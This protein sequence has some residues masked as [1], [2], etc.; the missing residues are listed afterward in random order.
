MADPVLGPVEE[1]DTFKCIMFQ[2]LYGQQIMNVLHY[3]C[4]DP[5]VT[6]PQRYQVCRELSGAL[7]APVTGIWTQLRA[8]Q[9]EELV[10]Q[11]HRVQFLKEILSTYPFFE[12][13][14][15]AE[16]GLVGEAKM[17]N[18]AL[19][20]EKRAE[21][22]ATHPRQ[23]VGRLQLAGVPNNKIHDG[24]F[25]ADY[26]ADFGNVVEDMA[27]TIT[28][29]SGVIVAPVL[30]YKGATLWLDNRIFACSVHPEVRTMNR[31]TVGRGK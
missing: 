18:N 30:S 22:P 13:L 6:P 2:T 21:F 16:G 25:D 8:N 7:T 10:H 12:E 31:R 28:L 19:S 24:Q 1:G 20:I 11:T 27:D 4:I 26:L 9:V 17:S 3:F 15:G 5:T 14:I 23:G 29:A